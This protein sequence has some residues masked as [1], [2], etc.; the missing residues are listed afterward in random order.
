MTKNERSL[1]IWSNSHHLCGE[2]LTELVDLSS[3]EQ[4]TE[5][6]THKEEGIGRIKSDENDRSKI[7]TSLEKCIH[8]L[9]TDNHGSNVLVNM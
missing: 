4:H 7:E 5:S 9:E 2:V 8:P 3:K 1:A 6:K